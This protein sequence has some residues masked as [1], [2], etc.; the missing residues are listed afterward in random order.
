MED[1]TFVVFFFFLVWFPI[2]WHKRTS[3]LKATEKLK[4]SLISERLFGT[5]EHL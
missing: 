4:I 5:A 1:E 2:L 3:A